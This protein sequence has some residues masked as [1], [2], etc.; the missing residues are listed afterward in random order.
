M[1]DDL[2]DIPKQFS[3]TADGQQF[4]VLNDAVIPDNLS[5]SAHRIL[6]FLSQHGKEMLASCKCWYIDGTFKAADNALFS[7]SFYS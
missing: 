4:L 6:V 7:Q 1:F 3:K 5:P 2:L